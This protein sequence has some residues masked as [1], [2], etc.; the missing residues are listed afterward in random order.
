MITFKKNNMSEL[1][2]S[3]TKAII[4]QREVNKRMRYY[5]LS[6]MRNLF[7]E[8][9][10]I[11]EYGSMCAK[12]PTQRLEFYFSS[13]TDAYKSLEKKYMQ[14]YKRGYRLLLGV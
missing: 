14:K 4:L 6:V 3:M 10:F 13:Y 5:K 12:K 7:G 9:I 11:C 2:N 8:Y 1:K